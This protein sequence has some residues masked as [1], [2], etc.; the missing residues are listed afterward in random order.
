MQ[1]SLQHY[2]MLS[3]AKML[4]VARLLEGLSQRISHPNLYHNQVPRKFKS[5]VLFCFF[6]HQP[7]LIELL[8]ILMNK[9]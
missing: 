9:H 3:V 8:R 5:I 2:E 1:I 7:K 6:I 4:I